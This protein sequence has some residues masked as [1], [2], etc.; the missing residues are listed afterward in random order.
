MYFYLN[1]HLFLL[2]RIHLIIIYFLHLYFDNSFI[3]WSVIL[4]IFFYLLSSSADNIKYSVYNKIFN[5]SS[6]LYI[7]F[8]CRL[9]F[10]IYLLNNLLYRLF[11]VLLG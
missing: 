3:I 5:I 2:I 9:F 10:F 8:Y 7:Y 4:F 6:L 11:N 1:F